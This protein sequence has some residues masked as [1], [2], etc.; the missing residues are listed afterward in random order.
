MALASD[1]V[2]NQATF[3]IQYERGMVYLDKC[4]SLMLALQAALGAPHFDGNPPTVAG[5]ELRN[6]AERFVVQYGHRALVAAQ[7]W[8]PSLA[9]FEYLAPIAWQQVAQALDVGKQVVR[10]GV[11]FQLVWRADSFDEAR[12]AVGQLG[13]LQPADEWNS[14]F[15]DSKLAGVVG[16]L[17][18]RRG[19]L[20]AALDVTSTVVKV[21]LPPS[22]AAMV[23]KH[24]ILLDLD[25]IYPGSVGTV[26]PPGQPF[27]L[28]QSQAKDFVRT[29][30]DR[31]RAIAAT[32]AKRIAG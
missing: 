20:R 7:T 8:M 2:I 29:S 15:G 25:H 21:E 13:F 6:D 26:E 4:G 18:D 24:A 9:R 17:A 32:L 3:E 27:A 19:L 10:F 11:R 28:S 14:L 5:A 30:W 1:Y 12:S 23:P 31:S 16:V 22:L